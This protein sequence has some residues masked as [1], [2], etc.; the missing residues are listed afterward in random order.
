M[1]GLANPLS[2]EMDTLANHTIDLEPVRG[3]YTQTTEN[4]ARF[5]ESLNQTVILST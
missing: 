5:D 3:N 1:Y 4:R 2:E